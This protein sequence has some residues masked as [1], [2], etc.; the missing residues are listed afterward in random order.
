MSE[1]PPR[2][3]TTG[4]TGGMVVVGVAGL[5]VIGLALGGLTATGARRR[6]AGYPLAALAG[7]CFPISWTVWYVRD[8]HPDRRR[9]A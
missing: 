2:F 6:G 8:Q 7:L 1:T 9:R 5:A 3:A 4:Q